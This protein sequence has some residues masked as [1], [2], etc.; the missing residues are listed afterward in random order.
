M[1]FTPVIGTHD[2]IFHCDD[3]LAVCLLKELL[4]YENATVIRTRDPTVLGKCAVVVDV[5]GVHDRATNRFDHHQ[6]GFSVKLP[7]YNTTLSS[8]G[9]VYE[10]LG[11]TILRKWF[12]DE[13][14]VEHAFRTLYESFIQAIDAEDNGEVSWMCAGVRQTTHLFARVSRLNPSWDAP[15]IERTP[16]ALAKRFEKAMVVVH[17]A[18]REA[19]DGVKSS[20]AA[21]SEIHPAYA[22]AKDGVMVM[23]KYVPWQEHVCALNA[24]NRPSVKFVVFPNVKSEWMAQGVPPSPSSKSCLVLFP[25]AWRG[26]QNRATLRRLTGVSTAT[27]VHRNGF[28][29]GAETRQDA[30]QLALVAL[31]SSSLT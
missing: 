1:S 29:G 24:C 3:V 17:E 13:V 7:G 16:Q 15:D 10:H 6:A 26:E 8:A 25:D 4:Q 27:F 14:D 22:A 2:G 23:N 30:V 12:K 31:S 5:G 9:L 18:W 28:I 19:V 20:L 11:R 21:K